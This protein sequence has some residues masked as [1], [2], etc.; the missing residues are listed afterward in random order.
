VAEGARI[1][2]CRSCGRATL[3]PFL[4]L[5]TVPIANAL[6]AEADLASEEPRFPLRVAFCESCSLVQLLDALPADAIFDEA[7]PYFSSFSDDLLAHSREHVEHLLAAGRLGP[8]RFLVEVASNDGYLLRHA[9]ERGVPVLGIEPTPGPAAA[10]RELG[11]PTLAA[12]FGTGMA[13][14]LRREHGPADVI[15]ANNVMAHVPDL[16]GFVAG[17]RELVA[18]DGLI[19]I[20]NPWVRDLIDHAE[21]DT[22]YHEH[23]CY[24]STTAVDALMTRHG[25]HLNDVAYYPK[26]HGGTLR[27]SVSPIAARTDRCHAILAEEAERGLT[28]FAGYERFGE[29]VAGIAADLRAL[30]GG[31]KAEGRSIAAYGATAKGSTLVNYAGIDHRTLDFVADRNPHKQG[32]WT[33][34]ARLPIVPAEALLERQPD[35]TLLLAWNFAEEIMRQQ[36]EYRLRG[37]RF[38][39]PIPS[40]VIA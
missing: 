3:R 6:L 22:I 11:I 24:F 29:R 38:I 21:F 2:A 27:W 32:R 12:F 37:G 23:W 30:L 16:N 25:L 9:V 15:V 13:A 20:E 7:Y 31:L 14:G 18:D 40:P 10:A 28:V 26:L 33:P 36:E 39:V 19:E 8:G 4:D 17:F 5:G 1:E 34:G 35:Y